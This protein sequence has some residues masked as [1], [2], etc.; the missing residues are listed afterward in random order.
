MAR[1][2]MNPTYVEDRVTSGLEYA[3]ATVFSLV[4][5]FCLGEK[6][7]KIDRPLHLFVMERSVRSLA[8]PA[9]RSG[10]V[11]LLDC[12]VLRGFGQ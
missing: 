3:S 4:P 9:Q 10:S 7:M 1:L 5:L 2:P 8:L 12:L 6:S 11:C